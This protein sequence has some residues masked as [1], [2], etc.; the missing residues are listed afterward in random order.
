MAKLVSST[1]GDALFELALEENRLDSMYEEI[2]AAKEVFLQNEELS[3]LL[4]HPKVVKD[5]KIAFI[6]NVFKGRVS[7]EVMGFFH[8][9]VTKDR[10]NDM[11]DIFDYFL[12]KVKEHKGIGTAHVTS[13][14]VL[15]EEQKAAVEKRLLETTRYQSFEMD[16]CVD[17]SI[18]GGLVIRIED[19][20]VDSSLKTQLD[21]LTKQ[22]SKIQLS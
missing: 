2:A 10:Y 20:V 1:Y 16:Y 17:P 3:K 8:I 6:E 19:R 12:H 7:E 5:E 21:K 13:A 11:I 14:I 22:L 18:L 9:I 4:N 15:S